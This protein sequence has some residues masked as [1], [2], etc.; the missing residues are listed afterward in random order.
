MQ[1]FSELTHGV[2]VAE[3]VR[4]IPLEEHRGI[5][6]KQLEVLADY[7]N[8]RRNTKTNAV[9]GWFD[10]FGGQIYANTINLRNILEL[11]SK[12]LT[13]PVKCS[14]VEAVSHHVA[15]QMPSWFASHWWGEPF[16]DFVQCIKG[17]S[18]TRVPDLCGVTA[19]YWVCAFAKNQHVSDTYALAS[20]E[21][22][23]FFK[24]MRVCQGVV[25]VVDK[26]GPSSVFQRIWCCYELGILLQHF[27]ELTIDCAALDASGECCLLT[28]GL[29]GQESRIQGLL[30]STDC[31][32]LR[33]GHGTK[34]KREEKFPVQ[35][36]RGAMRIKIVE[37]QATTDQDR[38]D[39]LDGIAGRDQK[40]PWYEFSVNEPV[41]GVLDRYLRARLARTSL[42]QAIHQGEGHTGLTAEFAAAIADEP[43]QEALNLNLAGLWKMKNDDVDALADCFAIPGT[44]KKLVVN[45]RD[46][47]Q[48]T[49]VGGLLDRLEQ[50]ES[51]QYISFD[52]S[53]CRGLRSAQEITDFVSTFKKGKGK[54][55]Q[56]KNMT[57][58]LCG[59]DNIGAL[60]SL[61]ETLTAA[62]IFDVTLISP[63]G[64]T[65]PLRE[66]KNIQP[67]AAAKPKPKP[68][69]W[70]SVTARMA[71]AQKAMKR[72]GSKAA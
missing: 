30:E 25:L 64:S 23:S 49:S 11:V 4:W 12:P 10:S 6:V 53:K 62:N 59:C 54:G 43:N 5:M 14:Y 71:W 61:A 69:K 2:P 35:I 29:T 50:V 55:A 13:Q 36:M 51:L 19:A 48:I 72:Q 47:Y 17:H 33:S 58:N 1:D 21:E 37:A 20:L 52:F 7:I 27:P 22:N 56:L 39:I 24:A 18:A 3:S 8:K 9:P 15:A 44:V 70:M 46:C 57:L 31:G 42:R 68:K 45:F 38:I 40:S 32:D 41:Y 26:T 63:D 67:K 34:V 65:V 60:D 16:V 28:E 66:D